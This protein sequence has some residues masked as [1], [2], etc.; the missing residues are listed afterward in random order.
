[1]LFIACV[2]ATCSVSVVSTP[3]CR[4]SILRCWAMSADTIY[5]MEG[6]YLESWWSLMLQGISKFRKQVDVEG[7]VRRA[8]Q[9]GRRRV[10]SCAGAMRLNRMLYGAR[11]H[12]V[13][14]ACI[15]AVAT[16][17]ALRYSVRWYF[18][19]EGGVEETAP[20]S[21]RLGKLGQYSLLSCGRERRLKWRHDR[22][23][24]KGGEIIPCGENASLEEKWCCL[25]V[26]WLPFGIVEKEGENG[27]TRTRRP[28]WKGEVIEHQYGNVAWS[29]CCSSTRGANLIALWLLC[30]QGNWYHSA[31]GAC[32]VRCSYTRRARKKRSA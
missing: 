5:N 15:C 24:E 28:R 32:R 4:R 14:I 19:P 31:T 23:I 27:H 20:L 30:R 12:R 21:S 22:Y 18:A 29:G 1:M 8:G 7:G 17:D 16:D 25:L 26:D 11:L 9:G 3:G 13:K 10:L 2:L 6:T